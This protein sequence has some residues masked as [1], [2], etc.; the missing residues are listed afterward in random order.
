MILDI[1]YKQ[2]ILKAILI[3]NPQKPAQTLITILDTHN[4][5]YGEESIQQNHPRTNQKPQIY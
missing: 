3:C 4:L 5:T 1:L 2:T